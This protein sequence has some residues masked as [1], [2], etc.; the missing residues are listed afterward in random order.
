MVSFATN[1][2][3]P[4]LTSSLD[5]HSLRQSHLGKELRHQMTKPLRL[6]PP[7]K[8]IN[9]RANTHPIF[10]VTSTYDRDLVCIRNEYP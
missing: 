10:R 5:L 4:T 9:D 3:E 6:F 8:P 1:R 2:D 7:P